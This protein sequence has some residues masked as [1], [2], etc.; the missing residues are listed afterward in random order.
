MF[1]AD[2]G[3]RDRTESLGNQPSRLQMDSLL[4]NH[5]PLFSDCS[6]QESD[7]DTAECK[8]VTWADWFASPI[9]FEKLLN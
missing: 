9:L 6:Y 5:T 4:S 8:R 7:N 2:S 1:S 3:N